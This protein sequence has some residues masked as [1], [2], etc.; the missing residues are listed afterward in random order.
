MRLITDTSLYG[1]IHRQVVSLK[2]IRLNNKD[3]IL[4]ITQSLKNTF[5][6]LKLTRY[7]ATIMHDLAQFRHG[8]NNLRTTLGTAW[9][10]VRHDLST[11]LEQLR[12]VL[13]TLHAQTVRAKAC[14][15]N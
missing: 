4:G 11:I 12:H 6:A 15:T 8:L 1:I 13:R 7:F 14:F 9:A 10:Q 3:C 2:F 5:R